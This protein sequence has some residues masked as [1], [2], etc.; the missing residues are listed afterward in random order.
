MHYAIAETGTDR[1][2]ENSCFIPARTNRPDEFMREFLPISPEITI[3][4]GLNFCQIYLMV[5]V[6][7]FRAVA[8]DRE[9]R[10]GNP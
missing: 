5:G 3:R 4:I 10:A 1:T 9:R 6:G 8:C 2:Q 7:W